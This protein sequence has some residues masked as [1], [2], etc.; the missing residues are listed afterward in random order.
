MHR[1][2]VELRITGQNLDPDAITRALGLVPTLVRKIGEPKMEGATARWSSNTW[3][4]EILPR[5]NDDWPSLEDGLKALL[6]T[7]EPIREKLKTCSAG[8]DIYFWCGHFTSSFDG[9][10]ILSPSLL[11]LLGD[12][13]VQLF[14]ETYCEVPDEPN[15]TTG[16]K[17]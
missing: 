15:A 16:I 11:K 12:F 4:Y 9:G 3:G 7:L 2:T 14:L 17:L 8:N 10:P 13:G 6:N 1:Y 5:S